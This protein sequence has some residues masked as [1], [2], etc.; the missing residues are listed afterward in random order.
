MITPLDENR[1]LSSFGSTRECCDNF[2]AIQ[3]AKV[4]IGNF[5]KKIDEFSSTLSNCYGQI[6]ANQITINN[7][8]TFITNMS[9]YGP[10]ESTKS[11]IKNIM[12]DYYF[13]CA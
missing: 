3:S 5:A 2:K 6:Q 13:R 12:C 10:T 8:L 7:I 11:K 9:N 4:S 1:Y